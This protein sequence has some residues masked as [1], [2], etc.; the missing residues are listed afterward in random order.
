MRV[1]ERG[2]F[3]GGVVH[4]GS[5]LDQCKSGCYYKGGFVVVMRPFAKLFWTLVSV[6]YRRDAGCRNYERNIIRDQSGI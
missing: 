1:V 6:I 3:I 4:P 2:N 5:N